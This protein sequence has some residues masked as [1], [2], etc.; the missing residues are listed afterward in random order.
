MMNGLSSTNQ[1]RNDAE[2]SFPISSFLAK[3]LNGRTSFSA[4]FSFVNN[5]I[6]PAPWSSLHSNSFGGGNAPTS[7]S[8]GGGGL[9]RGNRL[10]SSR[11]ELLKIIETKDF[12]E[13]ISN[14]VNYFYEFMDNS[15]QKE[16]KEFANR[17]G[18]GRSGD[19]LILTLL[20]VTL[21]LV[22]Q[23]LTQLYYTFKGYISPGSVMAQFIT[24]LSVICIVTCCCA[25]WIIFFQEKLFTL[26]LIQRLFSLTGDGSS[27][28]GESVKDGCISHK[29]SNSLL[30]HN[31]Q[32]NRSFSFRSRVS[33]NS[34]PLSEVNRNK[35]LNSSLTGIIPPIKIIPAKTFQSFDSDDESFKRPVSFRQRIIAWIS[36]CIHCNFYKTKNESNPATTKARILDNLHSYFMLQL[37]LFFILEFLR[38]VLDMNCFANENV[39]N[40]IHSQLSAFDFII[41]HILGNDTC[42]SSTQMDLKVGFLNAHSLQLFIL[43][44]IFF[45]G[46]PQTPIKIIWINYILAVITFTTAIIIDSSYRTFPSGF[47]WMLLTF[48]AIRDFQVRN[49]IIF[50]S[51]RNVKETMVSKNKAMEEN[52]ANEMR[53]LIAN[54]AHDLKTVSLFYA[55]TLV[56]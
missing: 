42:Y 30:C 20:I 14:E 35:S 12:V 22:P 29:G 13:V 31:L 53:S 47:I 27:F 44:F 8:G 26:K 34:R 38:I 21:L 19:F 18:K 5:R 32:S 52:H 51:T 10:S 2:I 1:Q 23:S 45:K 50:L 3:N 15:L 7:S 55:T 46:L 16:F 11:A 6:S 56:C 4:A 43:P 48:F 40:K 24:S 33:D 17:H 9:S 25:G 37:Q 49:M 28:S 36:D 41:V 54:V 39:E